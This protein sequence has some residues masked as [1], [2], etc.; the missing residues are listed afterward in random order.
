V[1]GRTLGRVRG[2]GNARWACERVLQGGAHRAMLR[3]RRDSPTFARA[4]AR[5]VE[6]EGA[7]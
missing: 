6:T 2:G 3:Q 7:H 4:R 1:D 5:G